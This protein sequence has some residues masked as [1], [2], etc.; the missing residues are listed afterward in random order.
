[1]KKKILKLSVYGMVAFLILFLG[2][3]SISRIKEKRIVHENI[4]TLK[5]FCALNIVS[6]TEFCTNS[7][8][9][10]PVI[11]MFMHPECDFCQEE[12]KQLKE[13]PEQLEDVYILLITSASIK[14]AQQFYEDNKLS[15]LTNLQFLSDENMKLSDYFDANAIPSIFVYNDK[16][17]LVYKCVGEIKVAALLK[18]LDK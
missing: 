15:Q 3:H 14:H 13:N 18:Y 7:L 4:Q 2:I 1:M 12:I 5:P 11:V 6:G 17:K 9:N 16:W 8:P 10:K